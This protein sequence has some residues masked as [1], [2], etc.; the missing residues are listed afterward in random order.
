MK[1]CRGSSAQPYY[2]Q[3]Y[4]LFAARHKAC[5]K[6][7]TGSKIWLFMR[8]NLRLAWWGRRHAILTDHAFGTK[9]VQGLLRGSMFCSLLV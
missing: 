1:A 6:V 2:K 8:A 9:E 5:Q 3:G 7:S 4:V